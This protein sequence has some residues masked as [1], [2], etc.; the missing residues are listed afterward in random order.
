MAW[1]VRIREQTR[2]DTPRVELSIVHERAGAPRAH[3]PRTWTTRA[4]GRSPGQAR[5]CFISHKRLP[6][7]P[8][9]A[10][11]PRGFPS[12]SRARGRDGGR[13]GREYAARRSE[14]LWARRQG[15]AGTRLV[16]C[17]LLVLGHCHPSHCHCSYLNRANP[18]PPARSRVRCGAVRTQAKRAH[19]DTVTRAR[20]ATRRGEER[21]RLPSEEH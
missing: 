6:A 21:R 3:R 18:R 7:G 4:L 10:P 2:H 12:R 1:S 13:D 15:Q 11:P 9:G 20:N 5:F 8:A 14:Q 17:R 16:S 19:T